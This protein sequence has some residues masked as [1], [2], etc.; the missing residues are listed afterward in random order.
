M[1]TQNAMSNKA[2]STLS[3]PLCY[4][5]SSQDPL[6]NISKITTESWTIVWSSGKPGDA[7]YYFVAEN[8]AKTVYALVIR[9]SVICNGVFTQWD[10]F[11]DWVLEDMNVEPAYWPF[12]NKGG[13]FIGREVP[14]IGAGAYIAFTQMMQATNKLKGS[15]EELLSDFLVSKTASNPNTQLLITG[16]SLGGNL[17]K[18]YASYYVNQLQSSAGNIKLCTF[19]A[20][21]SGNRHFTSDLM[22]KLPSQIHYQNQ[23]DIVPHLLTVDGINAVSN[24]YKPAPDAANIII[25][26]DQNGGNISLKLALEGLALGFLRMDY[27][28]PDLFLLDQFETP[29]IPFDETGKKPI[30]LWLA[31]G[32]AQ[33]QIKVYAKYG[34]GIDLPDLDPQEVECVKKQ[35][36]VLS[37]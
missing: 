12:Y 37:Y 11:V 19:A 21:A 14:C 31:Q 4:V 16:H 1:N 2:A 22:Q 33:H 36:K 3:L 10:T 18:V 15:G 30:D 23:N 8:K 6:G 27:Q 32:A 24:F 25:G 9:G 17:A 29:L 34:V 35:S 5:A 13:F 20:P 26:Q 7:N 28:Q